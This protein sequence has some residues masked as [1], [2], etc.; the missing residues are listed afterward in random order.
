MTIHKLIPE[1]PLEA[2]RSF[3]TGVD[4][5]MREWAIA[6]AIVKTRAL[7]S[8][9]VGAGFYP[10]H[11]DV[12]CAVRGRLETLFDDL[13]LEMNMSA[14]RLD[15]GNLLLDG[16]GVFVHAWGAQ[17]SGYCSCTAEIW[18]DSKSR[19]DEARTLLLK[20]VAER[21]IVAPM[22]SLDWQFGVSGNLHSTSFEEI[23]QEELH[24]EAYP[25][26]GA[27]VQEFIARYLAANETVL[28]ILGPPGGG[29][30]RLVRSILGELSRRK[31]ASAEI[32]YTCDKKALEGDEIFVNFITGTH[33]AFVVE[34]ADHILTPRANGNQDLHRFLAIADGLVRAQGRKIIFTT[35]LPNVGD[36]DDALLRPG[37]CFAAIHTR[38]LTP[39]EAARLVSR[40]CKGD[41]ARERAASEIALPPGTRTC[42]VASVYRACVNVE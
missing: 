26:L 1:S 42:S 20:I 30:T 13:A 29:K 3:E 8:F 7:R 39:A 18:A 6:Q 28:V 22:I 24:D 38:S 40:L 34:D 35:N 25:G 2:A 19:A 37:R 27:P 4:L 9:S 33:D 32:M 10:I 36:L 14:Q 17:K 12:S 23:V 15:V 16:P 11:R 5:Q 31:G 21:R 41:P